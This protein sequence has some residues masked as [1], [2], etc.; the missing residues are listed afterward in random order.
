MARTASRAS[1]A[2][3]LEPAGLCLASL[4]Q[5][6]SEMKA[7]PKADFYLAGTPEWGSALGQEANPEVSLG[8]KESKCHRSCRERNGLL[9]ETEAEA[10]EL[11]KSLE[12]H[13]A[14]LGAHI[15]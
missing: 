11:R 2:L 6:Q 7:R 15:L 5:L 4:R 3:C 12:S 14:I 1:G 13:G 9:N 8:R 10:R